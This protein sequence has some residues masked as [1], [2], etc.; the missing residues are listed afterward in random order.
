MYDKVEWEC[1]ARIM[2]RLGFDGKVIHLILQCVATTSLTP[3]IN[4]S[5]AKTIFPQR[6]LRQGDPI[7]PYLFLFI[8]E[9]FSRLMGK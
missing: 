5:R 3:L 6:G 8:M 9:G 2:E 1:L 7:S 4:G